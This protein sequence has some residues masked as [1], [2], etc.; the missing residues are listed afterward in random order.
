MKIVIRPHLKIRLKE[1]IISSYYPKEILSKPDGE[2]FDNVTG[3]LVTVKELEYNQKIRPMVLVHDIIND[4][5]EII[6]IYPTSKQE[7]RNRLKSKRW[8]KR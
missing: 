5:V 7:I 2:Y 8:S 4:T 1:R 3:Y 6:T